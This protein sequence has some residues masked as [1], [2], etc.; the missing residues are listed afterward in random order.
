MYVIVGE[1]MNWNKMM[2]DCIHAKTEE[3][4]EEK[5]KEYVEKATEVLK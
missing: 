3:E 1:K 4:F 5:K 2:M